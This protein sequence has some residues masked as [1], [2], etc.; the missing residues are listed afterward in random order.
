M[1]WNANTS[2]IINCLY[3]VGHI[4]ITEN[5]NNPSTYLGVGIWVAYGAG[6]VP[7]GIDTTQTEFATV[8]Q[9]GGEKTH[10][11][12][13]AE[14]AQHNHGAKLAGRQSTCSTGSSLTVVDP[15]TTGSWYGGQSVSI[16]NTGSNQAHNNLQPYITTYMWKRTA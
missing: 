13:V 14:L 16:D 7:V 2:A 11:L 12:S 3:P 1:G 6:K 8:G 10:T 5:P 15:G 9:T 4:L